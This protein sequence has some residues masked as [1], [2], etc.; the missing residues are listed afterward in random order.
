[1][2]KRTLLQ[3]VQ[4]LSASINGDE[5]DTLTESVEVMDIVTFLRLAFDE[6]ISRRDWEFLKNRPVTCSARSV[7]DA[8]INR[9]KI[10]TNVSRVNLTVKYRTPNDDT[11]SKFKTLKYLSPLE[12]L[13]VVLAPNEPDTNVSVITN[14]EGVE[15]LIYNDRAPTYYTSFDEEYLWFDS[16]DATEGAGVVAADTIIIADVIP[17]MDWTEPTA[18]LPVPEQME[19]LIFNEALLLCSF[20]LR[21]MPDPTAQIIASRQYAKM[22]SL[23]AKTTRDVTEID[24]GRR[25]R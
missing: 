16:Y 21:Q 2:A 23:E 15:M 5:V 19:Q 13:E 1:M 14:T 10:P 20:R 7:G 4:D 17:T 22:V 11:D 3:L 24:Y 9:L 12:F 18:T 8:Q 6:V 25:R